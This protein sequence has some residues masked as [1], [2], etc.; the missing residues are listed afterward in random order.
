MKRKFWQPLPAVKKRLNLIIKPKLKKEIHVFL[1]GEKW[2]VKI[3]G[4]KKPP[5]TFATPE[6]AV[7]SGVF[8][9]RKK[10]YSLIIHAKNG[11]IRKNN[12]YATKTQHRPGVRKL[13][14]G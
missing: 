3:T 1:S 9:A 8:F 4:T 14:V 2:A 7:L 10:H 5:R 12:R 6:F 11:E 13:K